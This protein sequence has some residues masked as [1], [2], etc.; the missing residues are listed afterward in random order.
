MLESNHCQVCGCDEFVTPL[1]SYDVY[2]IIDGKPAFVRTEVADIEFV[3]Y[4]R[5]C[6]QRVQFANQIQLEE[7]P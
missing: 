6:G 3:L 5:E 2:Q 1:N 4:C 7:R